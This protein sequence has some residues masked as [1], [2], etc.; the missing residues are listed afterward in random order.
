MSP[1]KPSVAIL[2]ERENFPVQELRHALERRGIRHTLL[3]ASRLGARVGAAGAVTCAGVV[4]DDYDIVLVRQVPG[5]SLE[6][7]IF[8]MDALHRLARL[9]VR[10]INPPLAI[11]R[12]VDKYVTSTLLA[13]AGIPTPETVVVQSYE[14][15]MGALERFGEVVAKPIFGAEG[16]GIVR[17]ADPDTGYRVFR[18]WEQIGAV[19]YLQRF[20]EHGSRDI[21]AFVI[22]HRV[23]AAM[24]R[25]GA[26]W[27][28]NVSAG[29]APVAMHLP[30]DWAALAIHA[31]R[32][33]G[34]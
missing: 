6:Q 13:E 16:R 5:G 9:G 32:A 3:P 27:K 29:A 21:R 18:A 23:V 34:A 17:I 19:Y 30:P 11:E 1:L 26:G 20:I 4:L 28:T 31:V 25:V 7:V 14:E 15:A 8:R 10:V 12:M 24:E 22:G 2:A 33:V